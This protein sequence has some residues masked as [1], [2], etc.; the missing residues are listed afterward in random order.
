M[1]CPECHSIRK[2]KPTFAQYLVD[3]HEIRGRI[4]RAVVGTTAENAT[5]CGV[6]AYHR[7]LKKI[8]Q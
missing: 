2:P 7:S 6:R 4:G 1:D 3:L 5:A 8:P